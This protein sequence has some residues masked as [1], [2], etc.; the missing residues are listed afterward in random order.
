MDKQTEF[1]GNSTLDRVALYLRP[2]DAKGDPLYVAGATESQERWGGLHATLC[3]FA[4]TWDASGASVAHPTSLVATLEMA[5][6]AAAAAAKPGVKRWRLSSGAL[7][8]TGRAGGKALMLLPTATGASRTLAAI[9]QAVSSACLLN[10]RMPEELHITIG[11][12][13]AD[14][15]RAALLRAQ[16]WELAIAKCGAGTAPLRV[17]EFRERKE[18]AW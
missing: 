11:A 9:A 16:R 2:L 14:S 15:V 12:S 13:D 8:P 5:H 6:A 10:P 17:T 4:P 18:L 1:E 7:L 3:G